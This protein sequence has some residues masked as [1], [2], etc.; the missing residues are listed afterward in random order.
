MDNRNDKPCIVFDLD[1]TLVNTWNIHLKTCY[2][3]ALEVTGIQYRKLD[4][5]RA[6]KVTERETLTALLGKMD[7]DKGLKF[8]TA[9]FIANLDLYRVERFE[10]IDRILE[11]LNYSGSPVGLFTG[12]KRET[13]M[14]LLEKTNLTRYFRSVITTDDVVR[15][16]PFEEGLIKTIEELKGSNERS[17]YIG[18]TSTDIE[19]SNKLNVSSVLVSWNRGLLPSREKIKTIIINDPDDLFEHIKRFIDE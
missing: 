14:A 17:L 12:R 8:Y 6:N 2:E 3:T 13:A 10:G 16:K 1:G 11:F 9:K 4:I 18:D 5:I 19:I 15:P 7:N